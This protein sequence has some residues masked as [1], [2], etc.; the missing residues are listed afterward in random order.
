MRTK[1]CDFCLRTGVFCSKCREKIRKGEVDEFYIRV[2]KAIMEILDRKGLSFDFY[3]DSAF[4]V[5]DA[6]VLMLGKGDIARLRP[7]LKPLRKWLKGRFGVRYVKF[8]EASNNEQEFIEELFYPLDILTINTVWLPDGSQVTRVVVRENERMAR[9]FMN[10]E[11]LKEIA[12]KAMGL[13]L[14]IETVPPKSLH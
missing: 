7:F 13:T 1:L 10:Y 6:L 9:R 12:K 4:K 5:G 8:L 14:R 2:A 11:L 3:L